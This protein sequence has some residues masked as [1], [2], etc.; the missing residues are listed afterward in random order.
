MSNSRSKNV[1]L[2]VFFG[3]IAQLGILL[4]SFLGRRIFIQF[5]SADY[6]GINGLYSNILSVLSLAELGIGSVTQFYLYRPVVENNQELVV[7]LLKYFRKLYFGVASVVMILGLSL[8]PFLKYIINSELPQNEFVLYYILFLLN[9]TV[10]YFSAPQV[11]LLGA[12]QDHR[13]YKLVSLFTNFLMQI[14]HIAVLF[15]WRNYIAYVLMT[16]LAS[17]C[18]VVFVD[19]LCKRKYRYIKNKIVPQAINKNEIAKNLKSTFFYKVGAVIVNNTD[20]ILIS[21]IVSTAAVGFYSNYFMVVSGVQGFIAIV[22]TSLISGIGNLAAEKNGKRLYSLFH[23]MLLVFHCMAAFG[24]IA[25]YLLFNDFI[26]VWLGEHYLMSTAVV[27]AIAF[28]FYL[29]NAIS[30]T[31][32]YREANGLFNKVRYL[33]IAVA[34]SNVIFSVI[35][36][37]IWGI[38]GILIAT[39]IARMVT[40]VWYE[41]RVLF[42]TVFS[43]SSKQY[44]IAQIKYAALSAISLFLCYFATDFMPHSFL[45]IVL[46]AVVIFVICMAV[47]FLGTFKSNE[48]RDLKGIITSFISRKTRTVDR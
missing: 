10:S 16:L 35:L 33:M 3:Y 23:T 37:K 1:L 12:N 47:F 2:N 34:V 29:T 41:P 8:I 40:M 38:F 31:W 42:K 32:M 27:F 28:N 19:S 4:L 9:S 30:P 6:L 7:S 22:T 43:C 48:F 18:N 46:K 20:N 36:G 25:F 11:A 45:F 24:G 5:L 15:I 21:I 13:L 39:A 14:L 26:A 17:V 44:W